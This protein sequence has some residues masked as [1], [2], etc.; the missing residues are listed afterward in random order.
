LILGMTWC[1]TREQEDIDLDL[2][3]L[4]YD[5]NWNY[6]DNCSFSNL[7][8]AGLEHSGD[9]VEAPYPDG[10]REA[11]TITFAPML[12]KYP[13]VRYLVVMVYS[14]SGQDMDEM[15]DGS[16]FVANPYKTGTGPGGMD[17]ISA[18]R[19][20]GK[21]T[22]NCAGFVGLES[23]DPNG[24]F[25]FYCVDQTF[26]GNERA[27]TSAYEMVAKHLQRITKNVE[28]E[29]PPYVRL[30]VLSAYYAALVS[31]HVTIVYDGGEKTLTYDG[32]GSRTDFYKQISAAMLPLKDTL[33]SNV[34]SI[35]PADKDHTH[36][37]VF[38]G[39]L[40]QAGQTYLSNPS[41]ATPEDSTTIRVVN[42]RADVAKEEKKPINSKLSV[43]YLTS[44]DVLQF[45]GA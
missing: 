33:S 21:G 2:S 23:G 18:A 15:Y 14:Y 25:T 7:N 34:P 5:G 35:L 36:L 1:Q 17:V 27:A 28:L 22:S 42:L 19:L 43:S 30:S 39:E 9:F 13:N 16:V 20:S 38:G 37:V 6:I 3:V 11:V 10:A 44:T 29:D 40:V 4:L 12:K 8:I 24:R 26:T 41:Y 32:K 45:F 31:D